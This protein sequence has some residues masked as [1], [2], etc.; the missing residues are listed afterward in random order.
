MSGSSGPSVPVQTP[1]S[2]RTSGCAADCGIVSTNTRTS[3]A[4]GAVMR[5]V[6][7]LLATVL[8]SMALTPGSVV[9]ETCGAA[10]GGAG[11]RADRRDR[12]AAIGAWGRRELWHSPSGT[13]SAMIV[14][15]AGDVL[16]L[17][18]QPDHAALARRIMDRWIADDLPASPRRASILRAI[19]EHDH[20]WLD[21]DAAP[22]VDAGHRPNR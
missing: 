8:I 13:M 18:T 5:N 14:R 21:V 17:I 20:G 9:G 16:H 19:E 1:A 12:T 7:V 6:I 4:F 11:E 15:P 3:F 2:S 10:A 22:I